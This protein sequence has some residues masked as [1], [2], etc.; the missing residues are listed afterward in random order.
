MKIFYSICIFLCASSSIDAQ[1]NAWQLFERE[2]YLDAAVQF[3]FEVFKSK[4]NDQRND[5]LFMKY[6]C[7]KN[8]GEYDRALESIGRIR[9]VRSDSVRARIGY[10]KSLLLYLQGEYNKS[11]LELQKIA[12]NPYSNVSAL[13][14][15]SVLVSIDQLRWEDTRTLI[16]NRDVFDLTLEM[17]EYILPE[18]LKSKDVN[19]AENL[20]VIPGLGQW[21]AGYFWRGATS[22]IIQAAIGGFM[23]YSL[24]EGYPLSGTLSGAA[25]LYTFNLGGARHAG[26]LAEKKNKELALGIKQ[27]FLQEIANSKQ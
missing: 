27:R 6:R 8:L 14:I 25:G 15:L 17:E 13:N 9:Y 5:L 16:S 18:K 1:S 24:L 23:M 3:E 7:Y 2:Q 19:K 21:Y 10:E 26:E 20:S 11:N 12:Q 4:E 22:G